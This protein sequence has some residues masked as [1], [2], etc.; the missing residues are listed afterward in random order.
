MGRAYVL[1]LKK[2]IPQGNVLLGGKIDT[3]T[4]LSRARGASRA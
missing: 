4:L 2:Q 3:T 1:A